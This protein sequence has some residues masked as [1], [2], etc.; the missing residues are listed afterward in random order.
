M[1]AHNIKWS[2]CLM[3]AFLFEALT[4][5]RVVIGVTFLVC[6]LINLMMIFQQISMTL[7]SEIIKLDL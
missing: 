5:L 1:N 2:I 4:G 3:G 6:C 7:A